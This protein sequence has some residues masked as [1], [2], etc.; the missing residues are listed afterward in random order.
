MP[1]ELKE[2]VVYVKTG[3]SSEALGVMASNFREPVTSDEG[4]RGDRDERE[5]DDGD[6]VVRAGALAGKESGLLSTV[7]NYIGDERFT[8]LTRHRTQW[9]LTS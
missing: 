2:G 1:G 6:T 9:R 4:G 3:N 8:L 5:D 7:C